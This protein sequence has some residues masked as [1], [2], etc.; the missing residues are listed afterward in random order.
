V[1]EFRKVM[2]RS[3]DLYSYYRKNPYFENR[4]AFE[5]F[6]EEYRYGQ[7]KGYLALKEDFY[8]THG[9]FLYGKPSQDR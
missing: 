4:E 9:K 1:Q 3:Q 5:K 6:C 8:H 2:K 7:K